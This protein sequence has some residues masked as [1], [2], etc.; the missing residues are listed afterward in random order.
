MKDVEV[1]S[2]SV[3]I[4]EYSFHIFSVLEFEE[5]R[6]RDWLILHPTL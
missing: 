6:L 4:N 5:D 2:M 1:P 3:L